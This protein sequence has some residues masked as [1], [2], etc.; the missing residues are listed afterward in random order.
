M[1]TKRAAD[2]RAGD[3]VI[4]STLVRDGRGI[5][6]GKTLA[7]VIALEPEHDGPGFHIAAKPTTGGPTLVI[8][9][10]AVDDDRIELG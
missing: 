10:Y 2:L 8:R 6:E 3:M 7:K 1:Q 5:T 4:L 9:S